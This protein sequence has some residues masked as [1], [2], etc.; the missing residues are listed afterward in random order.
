MAR[1]LSLRSIASAELVVRG[2][3]ALIAL[4]ALTT[5]CSG[6]DDGRAPKK[7]PSPGEETEW[8]IHVYVGEPGSWKRVDFGPVP[9]L[10]FPADPYV[11]AGPLPAS[12]KELWA[13][14]PD[15]KA[16]SESAKSPGSK[17][18]AVVGSG[19]AGVE[20]EQDLTGKTGWAL[21]AGAAAQC[22]PPGRVA[23]VVVP[24]WKET[25]AGKYAWSIFPAPATSCDEQVINSERL[26][27]IANE[28]ARVAE[29]VSPV[30]WDKIQGAPVQGLPSGPWTIP[31][32]KTADRFIVRDL[33]IYM[34]ATLA[35]NDMWIPSN[36]PGGTT[37][38][39]SSAY[40]QAAATPVSADRLWLFGVGKTQPTTYFPAADP[41]PSDSNIP[42]LT[43]TRLKFNTQILRGASRL[44]KE[45]IEDSVAADLAGTER[46]RGRATD[47]KRG[48][49]LA[50]GQRKDEDGP[51]IPWRMQSACSRDAGNSRRSGLQPPISATSFSRRIQPA[52]ASC[53]RTFCPRTTTGPTCRRASATA[54]PRR[55]ATSSRWTSSRAQAS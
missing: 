32:Q 21:V 43:N 10:S 41:L 44:L 26:L 42:D 12:P 48:S 36:A 55:P 45:L 3:V 29:A 13:A 24:P 52:A 20:F 9:E 15:G 34:L 38:T 8:A 17:P 14:K 16:P 39:C 19:D 51:T 54:A 4:F 47:P 2:V 53:A 30:H 35:L 11:G 5:A 27:C 37:T 23:G 25:T 6:D 49:E 22:Q 1:K 50:W 18:Q 7:S 40:A 31:P 46:R 28:L 33:A